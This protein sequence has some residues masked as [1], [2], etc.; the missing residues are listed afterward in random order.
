MKSPLCPYASSHTAPALITHARLVSS[1]TLKH[2]VFFLL[3]LF[4]MELSII[5][6]SEHI[7]LLAIIVEYPKN[8]YQYCYH[9]TKTQSWAWGW[10]FMLGRMIMTSRSSG[11]LSPSSQKMQIEI[12]PSHHINLCHLTLGQGTTPSHVTCPWSS[13]KCYLEW[14]PLQFSWRPR[15]LLKHLQGR[16]PVNSKSFI[17]ETTEWDLWIHWVSRLMKSQCY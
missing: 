1:C 2:G 14:L 7:I 16:L 9:L 8:I 15:K 5:I 3:N 12:Y 10:F 13:A 4:W 6:R 11:R 17:S